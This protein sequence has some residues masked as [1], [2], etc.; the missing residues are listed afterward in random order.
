LH[1]SRRLHRDIK[2][3]NVGVDGDGR[4]RLLDYGIVKELNA[5]AI[6]V[7][8]AKFVGTYRYAAPECLENQPSTFVSDLYSF[9]AT[10]YFVLH[11]YEIFRHAKTMPDLLAAKKNSVIG[12]DENL[13]SR[14]PVNSAL[15][16]LARR[17]LAAD[18]PQRPPS[19]MAC[20]DMLAKSIPTNVPFR[21][22][23]ACALTRNDD[24]SRKQANDAGLRIRR[25]G[26]QHQFSL[27]MPGE[28]THPAG[29]PELTAIE[30][31]WIDRE[32]VASS[33]LIV[34]FCD[35]PSFGVGQEAEIAANAGVPILLFYGKG[36]QV[37][38]M[39]RGVPASIIGQI[40]YSDL[41]DL[42][43]KAERFF[44]Q[45]KTQL[46]FSRQN[47]DRQYQVRVGRRVR[48]CRESAGLS[49]EQLA[50]QADVA[51]E[52]VEALET[53]PEQQSNFSLVNL[54]R[55]ARV[56]DVSPAELMKD[57]SGKDQDFAEVYRASLENLRTFAVEHQLAYAVYADLKKRGTALLR[58]EF[59]RAAARKR[60]GQ[61]N[62]LGVE[63][64]RR[65]HVDSLDRKRSEATTQT[66]SPMLFS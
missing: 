55:I 15:V 23:F 65:L 30:V 59:D 29:S 43:A 10:L 3:S 33:D 22:Y 6:T 60:K 25:A 7:S 12:F 21:V 45:K 54:R 1:S 19:A 32:R 28:H 11:G 42:E 2:P 61:D 40:E 38:R 66:S 8:D 39:L 34:I 49:L 16:E 46:A 31:H 17:L 53:R 20:W 14:G 13:A 26:A 27:Y 4:I 50:D 18:P 64:W 47:R 48:L 36:T 35:H 44:Q 62:V 41:D 57:Q 24:A 5:P 58:T 51:K 37:S 63:N 9:G 56:L 52:Q